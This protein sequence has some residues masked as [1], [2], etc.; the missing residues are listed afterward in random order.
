MSEETLRQELNDAYKARAMIYYRVFEELRSEFGEEK[1]TELLKKAIYKHGLQIAERFKKYAPDDLE[2]LR[3]AFMAKIP[4]NAALFNPE[5][6]RCDKDGLDI[7]LHRCPLKMVWLENGISPED[8]AKLTAIAGVVD[9]A[10]FEG[11]GFTFTA[12]TWQPGREGC[13][14]LK[15]RPDKKA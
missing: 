1:A 8:V 2:G 5:V 10:T 3:D 14:L 4:D 11:A 12:E 7:Q 9:N 6:L 15:I 13:C